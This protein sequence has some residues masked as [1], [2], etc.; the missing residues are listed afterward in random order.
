MITRA[1]MMFIMRIYCGIVYRIKVEGM[2]NLPKDGNTIICSN[3]VHMLDSISLVIRF[4]TKRMI[5]V[6]A[7][8]ELFRNKVA[9]WAFRKA[10]AFPIK[11]GKGDTEALDVAK[12]YINKGDML[13][14][15]P[16]GTRNGLGKGLKMKKGA[17]VIA[18]STNSVIVPIGIKGDFKPFT[19]V[20]IRIGKPITMENYTTGTEE[21]NPRE[22]VDLTNRMR[23]EIIALRDGE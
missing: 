7:K 17:A 15:F 23:D 11:R 1:I 12:G 4:K 2:E 9:A 18:L 5:R 13:L 19:K 16:E 3:H 21:L 6:M 8:E 10:G 22:I 14:I 20:R